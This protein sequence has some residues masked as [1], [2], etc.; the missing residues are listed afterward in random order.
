MIAAFRSGFDEVLMRKLIAVG[1]YFLAI[2]A[3]GV[4]LVAQSDAVASYEYFPDGLLKQI[5]YKN[6]VVTTFGYY[7]NGWLHTIVSEKPSTGV[8]VNKFE[9]EYDDD[10]NRTVVREWNATPLG[11]VDD[12]QWAMNPKIT[13]CGYDPFN[14]LVW[15]ESPDGRVDYTYDNAGNHLTERQ[16][17]KSGNPI[18]SRDLR[19]N[20]LNQLAVIYDLLDS[21]KCVK[22][23][24]DN[25][26]YTMT[27]ITGVIDLD[28]NVVQEK[29]RIEMLW[30]V[31]GNLRR[32]TRKEPGQEA[33]ILA[34][35][36]YDYQNRRVRSDR[37]FTFQNGKLIS[38]ESRLYVYDGDSVLVEYLL[39][40]DGKPKPAECYIYG[41]SSRHTSG[42]AELPPSV[43]RDDSWIKQDDFSGRSS[44]F[45]SA[46]SPTQNTSSSLEWQ[47]NAANKRNDAYFRAR[48]E[49]ERKK[50]ERLNAEIMERA[51]GG[52]AS[53]SKP[54]G[55]FFSH[56]SIISSESSP[57]NGGTDP[58][59]MY[60][61]QDILGSTVGLTDENGAV[62]AAYLYDAWGNYSELDVNGIHID[63]PG[64]NPA[65]GVW[66]EETYGRQLEQSF[67]EGKARF[68]FTGFE[69]DPET[70]FYYA[71]VRF[72]DPVIFRFN[73]LDPL[74]GKINSPQSLNRY[75]YALNNPLKYIDPSG[76][77]VYLVS[78]S[79]DNEDFKLEAEGKRDEIMERENFD[80]KHDIVLLMRT[81]NFKQLK[82]QMDYWPTF[83]EG[84]GYGKVAEFHVFSHGNADW[85]P[86]WGK[87]GEP[88]ETKKHGDTNYNVMRW[89]EINYNWEKGARAYFWGCDTA[90]RPAPFLRSFTEDFARE[91]RVNSYGQPCYSYAYQRVWNKI[92]SR[93][94]LQKARWESLAIENGVE[95]ELVFF[96]GR[97]SEIYAWPPNENNK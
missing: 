30:D 51:R 52:K 56:P 49:E 46:P 83:L 28:G 14:R 32:V 62:A 59:V 58:V 42:Q 63:H 12:P 54:F 96:P 82:A 74:L 24:Y 88:A 37:N 92:W 80:P 20:T 36:S 19:Y 97:N 91:E 38:Q 50:I 17:S 81:V 13:T 31:R 55:G 18:R 21:T 71:R 22:Y 69:I 27:K 6:G 10:G 85:G 7:D 66:D 11:R 3:M 48:E 5:I 60:Y 47:M 73:S 43:R 90:K 9:Y 68:T 70:N 64:V 93:I 1:C 53:E 61:H 41:I 76:E 78:Y 40:D 95:K 84:R 8:L 15:V 23:I 44:G 72:Y 33:Q 39:G 77:T 26:G 57:E 25:S 89:G 29:S 86:T 87:L 4:C 67:L 2:G 16:V 94:G 45:F 34:E 35:Y 75:S 65:T 79:T